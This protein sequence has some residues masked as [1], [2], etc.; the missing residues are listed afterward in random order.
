MVSTHSAE[1]YYRHNMVA[2]AREM[3]REQFR[4]WN[5]RLREQVWDFFGRKCGHCG[6]DKDVRILQ[7]DHKNGGGSKECRKIGVRGIRKRALEH[8]KEYQLLCP[9]CNWTKRFNQREHFSPRKP[10]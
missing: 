3:K 7:I 2:E 9:N 4:S 5:E 8:P 1:Y 6:F 10:C